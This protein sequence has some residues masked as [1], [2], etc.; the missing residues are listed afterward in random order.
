MD[1]SLCF[2]GPG[3][4]AAIKHSVIF[5]HVVTHYFQNHVEFADYDFIHAFV[6]PEKRK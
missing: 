2:L 5:G 6:A 3:Q 1:L 4:V